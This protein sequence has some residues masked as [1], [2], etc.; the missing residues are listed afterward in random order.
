MYC[1]Q[2]SGLGEPRSEIACLVIEEELVTTIAQLA[3]GVPAA[4]HLRLVSLECISVTLSTMG[5]G[6]RVGWGSTRKLS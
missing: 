3:L 2:C 4:L 1:E 6:I 5:W